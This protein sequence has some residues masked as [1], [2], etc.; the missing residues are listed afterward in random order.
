MSGS[1]LAFFSNV[2][3]LN[4]VLEG[5]KI[6]LFS[7]NCISCITRQLGKGGDVDV[8]PSVICC[9]ISALPSFARSYA[10]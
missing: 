10:V 9:T 6:L 3:V 4:L 5:Y 1:H 7:M 2:L 8:N